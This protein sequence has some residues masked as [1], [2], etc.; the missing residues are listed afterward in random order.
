MRIGVRGHLPLQVQLHPWCAVEDADILERAAAQRP[1]RQLIPA[2]VDILCA[3][4]EFAPKVDLVEFDVEAVRHQP[5]AV[6]EHPGAQFQQPWH[7]VIIDRPAEAAVGPCLGGVVTRHVDRL[8]AGDV[9]NVGDIR[10]MHDRQDLG[11]PGF[12]PVP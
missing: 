10:G 2:Q 8:D 4:A 6:L 7:L 5:H 11:R 1:G 9:L 12:M 3:G